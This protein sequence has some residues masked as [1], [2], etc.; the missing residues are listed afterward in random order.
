METVPG[1]QDASVKT[2]RLTV[3]TAT[4]QGGKA[5][6]Y[7]RLPKSCPRGYLPVR[8]ALTFAGLGGLSQQTVTVEY[9]APCP[10]R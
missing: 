3:G 9:K 10:R 5:I 2:I 6:F 8:T 1:A 4:R 7:G